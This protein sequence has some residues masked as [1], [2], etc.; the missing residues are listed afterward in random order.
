M[1]IEIRDELRARLQKQLQATGS[2]N[3]EQVLVH[4]LETQEEQDRWLSENR[5]AVK[6]KINRGLGQLERGEVV[7]EDELD[8]LLRKRKTNL[9]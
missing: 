5:D 2:E 9:K 4:L 7:G 3:L 8:A 1:N 6:E